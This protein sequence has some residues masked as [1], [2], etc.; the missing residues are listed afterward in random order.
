[1]PI[2]SYDGDSY[3]AA[4]RPVALE[5]KPPGIETRPPLYPLLIAGLL[6]W[7]GSAP[8]VVL[9][10]LQRGLWLAT[11]LLVLASVASLRA[12]KRIAVA[13]GVA[14]LLDPEAFQM[15]SLVYAETLAVFFSVAS[16]LALVARPGPSGRWASAWLAV[17]S[18]WVRPIGQ[19]LLLPLAV[20]AVAEARGLRGRLRAA[21]PF[22]TAGV[23]GIGS[24][25]ALQYLRTGIPSFVPIAGKCHAGYLGDRR[26]LGRFPPE[27]A[28]IERLYERKFAADPQAVRFASWD[29]AREWPEAYR[30]RT[31]LTLAPSA[32]DRDM[33]RT[34]RAVLLANPGYYFSRWREVWQEFSTSSAGPLRGSLC[35]ISLASPAWAA[36]WRLFGAWVP[37]AIV[38]LEAILLGRGLGSP[39]RALPATIYL[40]LSIANTAI[41][42]W[43]GQ[44]RYRTQFVAFLVCAAALVPSGLSLLLGGARRSTDPLRSDARDAPMDDARSGC[45]PPALPSR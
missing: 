5:G 11:G 6:H 8:L 19:L 24:M 45:A 30:E 22:V 26:L 40:F 4:A 25:Y 3:L 33:G 44:I 37:F 18:A 9:V 35:P 2:L 20:A 34:A 13:A 43:P 1:M 10:H 21:I 16:M 32:L 23:I 14:F 28:P 27:Y 38:A 39:L 29:V 31:G 15:T 42:P 7:G 12:R 17:A 41:E 36:W